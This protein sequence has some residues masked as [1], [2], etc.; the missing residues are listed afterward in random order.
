MPFL[1]LHGHKLVK[2]VYNVFSNQLGNSRLPKT[3]IAPPLF[4]D[5]FY[6]LK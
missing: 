5:S 1:K 3:W 4:I 2:G 6:I